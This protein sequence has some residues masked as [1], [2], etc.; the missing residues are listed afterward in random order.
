MAI[1]VVDTLPSAIVASVVVATLVATTSAGLGWVAMAVVVM[2]TDAITV[3]PR[4][5]G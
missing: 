3:Q 2:S 5:E 1:E 4:A